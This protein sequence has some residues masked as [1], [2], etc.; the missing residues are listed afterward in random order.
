MWVEIS[1]LQ[2][3]IYEQLYSPAA[4]ACPQDELVRRARALAEDCQRL[5]VR[6]DTAR[7]NVYEFIKQMNISD[8]VDV[9]I[10]GDEVQYYVTQTL[11][12]RVI[13]APERSV[14]RFC[15]ECLEA[16][17]K[18]MGAHQECARLIDLGSF[19]KTIYVHW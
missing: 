6:G 7:N 14:S 8:V 16:A 18:A 15:D 9:F 11:I 12:Y 4:L 1:G 13:P 3:L 19:V 17:R 2:S 10:R 5:G